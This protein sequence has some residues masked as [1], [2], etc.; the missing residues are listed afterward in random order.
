MSG[1]VIFFD[2]AVLCYVL[3]DS[4]VESSCG[5][6]FIL[7]P[8]YVPFRS[9]EKLMRRKNKLDESITSDETFRDLS[10]SWR[11]EDI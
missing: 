3:F 1:H 6:K 8:K 7:Y 5:Q 11:Y 9:L 2:Y 10:G 4:I